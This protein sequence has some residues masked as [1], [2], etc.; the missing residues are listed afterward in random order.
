MNAIYVQKLMLIGI[1]QKSTKNMPIPNT[2]LVLG[3][4]QQVR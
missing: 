3:Q 1:L 2:N 4:H